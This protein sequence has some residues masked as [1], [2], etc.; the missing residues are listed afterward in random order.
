VLT[1][2]TAV[3]LLPSREKG[4]VELP[5]PPSEDVMGVLRH[6][7]AELLRLNDE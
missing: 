6:E 2:G 7:V 3:V 4:P 1:T 5:T